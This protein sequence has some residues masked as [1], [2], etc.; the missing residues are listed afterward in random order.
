V[1]FRF[2]SETLM[3]C[4]VCDNGDRVPACRPYVEQ[5][6]G[7][8]AVV[9]DVPVEECSACGEIWLDEGVALRLDAPLTEMLETETV[10]VR[11]FTDVEFTAA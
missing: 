10:A 3:R 5:R 11:P 7:K 2:S 4:T 1:D 8:V 6:G 9:T